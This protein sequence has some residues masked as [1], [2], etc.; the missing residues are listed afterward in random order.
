MCDSGNRHRAWP[1]GRCARRHLE[2]RQQQ[3]GQGEMP[4]YDGAELQ[5]EAVDRFEAL[6]GNNMDAKGRG[7]LGQTDLNVAIPG[8]IVIF[9]DYRDFSSPDEAIE[10][11]NRLAGR[12][13][14]IHLLSHSSRSV[15]TPNQ[16]DNAHGLG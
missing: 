3:A 1:L 16:V 6:A 2:R 5:F 9:A 14:E 8:D 4:E 7:G 11:R 12:K 10:L 13:I 15:E